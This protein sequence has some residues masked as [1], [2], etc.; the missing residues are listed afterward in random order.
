MPGGVP[1]PSI[2][3]VTAL[4]L[5]VSG[6]TVLGTVGAQVSDPSFSDTCNY[7][8]TYEETGDGFRIIE[9]GSHVIPGGEQ[10]E[11]TAQPEPYG[12]CRVTT[13]EAL[14]FHVAPGNNE[15]AQID[16]DLDYESGE[17][18][19]DPFSLESFQQNNLD[20]IVRNS[21]G[22][23]EDQ[24]R[25]PVEGGNAYVQINSAQEET[26]TTEVV[27]THGSSTVKK[28]EVDVSYN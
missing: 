18:L 14:R 2:A 28:L 21:T 11:A 1:R 23:I 13:Q 22:G 3:T 24:D 16:I 9:E 15:K 8:Y 20:I 25:N 27:A 7:N 5:V 12:E 10:G 26:L 19:R 4:L 6:F 17:I